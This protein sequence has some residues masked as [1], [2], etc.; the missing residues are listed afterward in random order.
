[1]A[2]GREDLL[3]E[4]FASVLNQLQSAEIPSYT[5][6]WYLKRHVEVDGNEHGPAARKLLQELCNND[7]IREQ[8]A[9]DAALQAIKAREKYWDLI[10]QKNYSF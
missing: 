5:F 2:L 6:N 8:E 9:T 4:Q 3:P 10:I 1:L 7:P